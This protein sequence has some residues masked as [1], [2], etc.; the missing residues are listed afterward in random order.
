MACGQ[1]DRTVSRRESGGS[2]CSG[3]AT[4]VGDVRTVTAAE[5]CGG[6]GAG[7]EVVRGGAI[8]GPWHTTQRGDAQQRLD[9]GIVGLRLEG[10]PEK[11]SMSMLPSA[12]MAPICRSPPGGR[13]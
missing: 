1:R 4:L 3:G 6:Q 13:C 8:A 5:V 10:V 12:T 11:I 9:V 2:A 7:D